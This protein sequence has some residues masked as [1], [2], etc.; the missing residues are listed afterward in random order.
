[1]EKF[2]SFAISFVIFFVGGMVVITVE[3][4][5]SPLTKIISGDRIELECRFGNF[6]DQ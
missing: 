4:N 3:A 5:S 1:M 2:Q 6:C